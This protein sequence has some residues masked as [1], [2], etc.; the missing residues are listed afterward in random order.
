MKLRASLSLAILLIFG[1]VFPCALRADT[2]FNISVNTSSLIGNPAGPYEAG[3]VLF[4]A[5][6][7]GDGNNTVTL[8]AFTFG[9]G[10]AGAV[11]ASMT[12]GN[13]AGSL[14]TGITLTDTNFV[15]GLASAF[16][17]GTSFSFQGS[18]TTNPDANTGATG[19]SG[20][21]F[22]FLIFDG[23]GSSAPGIVQTTDPTGNNALALATIGSTGGLTVQTYAILTAVPEPG[24]L[25]L[26]GLGFL[27]IIVLNRKVLTETA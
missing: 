23:I 8:S 17:P 25:L 14:Q 20:D 26:V 7:S 19:L 2:V 1:A 24:S 9:G 16:T 4:D 10:S 12:E 5:S 15:T 22:E 21:Q 6:G 11:D 18:M 3:F 13:P 27:A